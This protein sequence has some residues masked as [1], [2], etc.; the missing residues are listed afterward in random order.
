ML[1]FVKGRLFESH[2]LLLGQWGQSLRRHL[3]HFNLKQYAG[4]LFAAHDADA[5]VWPHP[6]QSWQVTSDAH[7][8]VS[9]SRGTANDH[10]EARNLGIGDGVNHLGAVAGDAAMLVFL[11]DDEA[12]NVLQED[13][14]DFAH[15]AEFD[16][17]GAFAARLAEQD[18][19]VGDDSDRIAHDAGKSGHQRYGVKLFEFG[20]TAAIDD[21]GDDF[22]DVVCL[23][24]I[25]R[26][27]ALEFLGVVEGVFRRLAGEL[28]FVGSVE[29]FD[30]VAENA[31]GVPVV[32]GVVVAD[33]G[34]AAVN[35]SST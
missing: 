9:G 8:V 35:V 15:R 4:S 30:D 27:G 18:A 12:G 11:A 32:L 19:V 23:A 6:N 25:G 26:G 20:K 2:L 14:W 31:Q 3:L 29:V 16:E 10:R 7:G 28:E 1:V 34:N 33:S 17:V 5:R 21:A 22:A 13:Q 24:D